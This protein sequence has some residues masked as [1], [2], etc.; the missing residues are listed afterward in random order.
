MKNEAHAARVWSEQLAAP[1]WYVVKSNRAQEVLAKQ[2]LGDLDGV[3]PYLPMFPKR[4]KHRDIYA[5]PLFR[6][7]LFAQLTM[8]TEGWTQIFSARGFASILGNGGRPAPISDLDIHRIRMA[9]HA[10][11]VR[12]GLTRGTVA[13]PQFEPGHAVKVSLALKDGL[14]Q[15][16]DA[17]FQELVDEKRCLVLW[18]L[19]GDSPRLS[20]VSLA[21]V[22]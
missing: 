20:R 8:G 15:E 14:H 19:I 9:E 17:V 3:E 18:K 5:V 13:V 12:M 4:G 7:Y 22:K 6:G 1:H 16:I 21:H 2:S 11:F 10:A